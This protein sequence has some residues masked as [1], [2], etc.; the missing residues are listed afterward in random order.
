MLEALRSDI[1]QVD[2]SL[3]SPD[4]EGKESDGDKEGEELGRHPLK[5]NKFL[6][7]RA[8]VTNLSCRF[9]LYS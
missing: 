4:K 2:L 1:A 7:L 9:Q 3:I 5:P 6:E 8:K